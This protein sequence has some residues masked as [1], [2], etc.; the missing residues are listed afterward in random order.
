MTSPQS[1]LF[2]FGLGYSALQLAERLGPQG[3]QVAGTVRTPAKAAALRAVG[4]DAQVWAGE[5]PID[6]P[7][8]AHWLITLP[9]GGSGCPAARA[10]GARARSAHSINY[11]STTG[12]YGDLKGGW[13]FEWSP[14]RPSSPRAAAR[15]TA[16]TQ[17][18]DAS[19]GRARLVRLPGIYGPGRSPFDRLRDGTAQRVIKPGQV[20]SRVHV[21]DIGSGLEALL[22]HPRA[23]GAFNL[24]DDLAAPPQDVIA[25]AADLLG[26]AP[27]SEV[28]IEE[29]ALSEMALSFY[30][31]CK[32]V[33]NARAKAALG[34]RPLYPT[35]HEG[36]RAILAA[37]RLSISS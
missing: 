23:T 16:E 29:A 20:F 4:I 7:A 36:L 8:G 3:W 28:L 17:W 12:V 14:L 13:A 37:E 11:L 9:P 15:V 19:D 35:Y 27:P 31:E 18:L 26:L 33:S 2:V 24:C 5:G 32:R 30:A 21:D 22:Q 6:V 1:L 10:A 25:H 34:W